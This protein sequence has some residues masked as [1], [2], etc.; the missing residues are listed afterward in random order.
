MMQ[1]QI[2]GKNKRGYTK[3]YRT[4]AQVRGNEGT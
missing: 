3:V 1:E 4:Q 2:C